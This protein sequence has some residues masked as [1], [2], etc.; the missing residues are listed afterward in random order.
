MGTYMKL[1]RI[2]RRI[3]REATG[4][5]AARRKRIAIKKLKRS[6]DDGERKLQALMDKATGAEKI[7]C[8]ND[9]FWIRTQRTMLGI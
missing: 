9:L 8:M 5:N 4:F 1:F 2:I 3:W 7:R 6:L